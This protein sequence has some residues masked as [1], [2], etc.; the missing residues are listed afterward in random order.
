METFT[1]K[2]T[3]AL[4]AAIDSFFHFAFVGLVFRMGNTSFCSFDLHSNQFLTGHVFN[5]SGLIQ[6]VVQRVISFCK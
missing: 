1:A 6:L 3:V 4:K 5:N 2:M